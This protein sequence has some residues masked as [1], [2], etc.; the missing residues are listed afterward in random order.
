M[1]QQAAGASR[2]VVTTDD[3]VESVSVGVVTQGACRV[4]PLSDRV[5]DRDPCAARTVGD[6]VKCSG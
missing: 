4:G 2:P 3:Q 5:G 6:I 1:Q